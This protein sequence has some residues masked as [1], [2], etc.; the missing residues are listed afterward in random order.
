MS[1]IKDGVGTFYCEA[2]SDDFLDASDS[3]GGGNV[4]LDINECEC[5][6]LSKESARELIKFLTEIVDK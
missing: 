3:G 6:I 4:C 2:N 1:E 5:V